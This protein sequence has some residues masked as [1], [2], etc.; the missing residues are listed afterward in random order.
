M[1]VEKL[2]P[3][4]FHCPLSK[5]GKLMPEIIPVLKEAP[6]R[7]GEKYIVD[8][9][10]H[11]LMPGQWPCIPNWHY[12]NVPRD[13][14]RNQLWHKRDSKKVMFL[15]V[16][17]D[18]LTEFRRPGGLP[19]NIPEKQWVEFTQFDEHRG[20][21]SRKHTWRIFIRLTPEPLLK[22]AKPSEWLRKHSQVYLD[23]NS[24][25]W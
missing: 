6:L 5:V 9:K 14:K 7:Q 20:T 23:V 4:L 10:V 1:K 18:P 25:K 24:F 15:W 16:S 11:M 8:A 13:K 12:D 17:G 19:M 2:H 3:G 22:A 21:M